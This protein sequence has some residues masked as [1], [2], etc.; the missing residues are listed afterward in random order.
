VQLAAAQAISCVRVC[1]R[2]YVRMSI[3][4]HVYG[5]MYVWLRYV[6]V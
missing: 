5:R 3:R 6:L 2:V 4:M 1:V